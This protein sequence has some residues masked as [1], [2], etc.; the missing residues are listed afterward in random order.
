[1]FQFAL[2]QTRELIEDQIRRVGR[3]GNTDIKYIFTVGGFA[4]SPFMHNQLRSLG[5]GYNIQV[6]SPL[7]P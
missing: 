1:M 4:A 7:F 2:T 3:N 6:V 5:L